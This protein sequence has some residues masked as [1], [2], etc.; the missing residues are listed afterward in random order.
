MKNMITMMKNFMKATVAAITV[1]V[2]AVLT[3][4]SCTASESLSV[5]EEN[6]QDAHA[7]ENVYDMLVSVTQGSIY[8]GGYTGELR[9]YSQGERIT[10]ML[11]TGESDSTYRMPTEYDYSD[12]KCVTIRQHVDW[13]TPFCE[14]YT[15]VLQLGADGLPVAFVCHDMLSDK[16]LGEG[17]IDF[18]FRNSG[19]LSQVHIKHGNKM[20]VFLDYVYSDVVEENSPLVWAS[21]FPDALI[22]SLAGTVG[23]GEYV[24]T[25]GAAR[26]DNHRVKQINVNRLQHDTRYMGEITIGDSESGVGLKLESYHLESIYTYGD[27][28]TWYSRNAD[29]YK[30][31]WL[32]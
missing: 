14:S 6:I 23:L 19:E 12:D 15:T 8:S 5:L 26:S 3:L 13:K 18:F 10:G 27:H 4:T 30:W 32:K 28:S 22:N 9:I 24:A 16:I 31:Y 11:L 20:E 17:S 7:Q 1:F 2:F 25:L 21:F 29:S